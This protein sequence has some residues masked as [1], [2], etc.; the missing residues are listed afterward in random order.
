M[1]F[2]IE[3]SE[4]H[5]EE[6]TNMGLDLWDDDEYESLKEIFRGVIHSD[7]MKVFLFL[8]DDEPA[9]F[10]FVSVRRDYVEGSDS[11]PT[12][13]VEGIYVKEKFRKTGIA[14]KLLAEGEKW[15]KGKGCNKIGSDAYIENKVS[16]DFHIRSGFTEA[17]KLVTFIKDIN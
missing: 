14:G 8:N 11:S 9:G 2:I 7:K 12:G 13:Y 4:K 3:A 6:L 17:A 15:V 10:I 1:E 16:Y 5:L